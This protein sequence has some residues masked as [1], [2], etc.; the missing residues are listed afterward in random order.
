MIPQDADPGALIEFQRSELFDHAG[1]RQDPNL[2]FPLERLRELA[3]TGRIGS[4]A[5][6]HVSFMGSITAP[7]RLVRDTAPEAARLLVEDRV[8]AAVLVPV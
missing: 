5:P 8:Q 7:G 2:A 6:R 1:M 4:V 3:V